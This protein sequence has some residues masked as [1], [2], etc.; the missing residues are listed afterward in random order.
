MPSRR[1][2][3]RKRGI[4]SDVYA[5]ENDNYVHCTYDMVYI[6]IVYF[7]INNASIKITR[8]FSNMYQ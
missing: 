4:C 1:E 7:F 8:C 3:L 2:R 6:D 5:P